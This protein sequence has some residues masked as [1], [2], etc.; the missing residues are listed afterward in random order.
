MTIKKPGWV[1]M[2]IDDIKAT[3]KGS[4]VSGPFG[5]NISAKYFTEDG[6][7][8][9]RGNNLTLG[10]KAFVDSGFVFI[11][12]EKA[13]ELRNCEAIPGDII[14]TAAGT[15]GQVGLIPSDGSYPKYIVSNKQLRLRC[16]EEIAVPE[17]LYYYFSAPSIRTYIANQNTGSSVPLLTLGILKRVPVALPPLPIQKKIASILSA[18]DD[19]IENNNRRIKILEEMAQNIY[20]EWFVHFRYPGH[21]DVPMVDSELGQIPQGW[22]VKKLEQFAKVTMGQSPK[23]EFYN[24]TGEGLPFHQGVTNFG[25]RYPQ[26]KVYCTVENRMADVGDILLSVRAPVGRMNLAPS[27]MVIGRGLC[28][29]KAKENQRWYLFRHLKQVF[30]EEDTMG[31][32]T[33]FQSVTKQEVV[34]IRL[35]V[36][37]NPSMQDFHG[38]V[39]P[40]E[41]EIG[42]FTE[43]TQN[44]RKTRDLLLPKL[45]SGQ[46]DVEELDIKV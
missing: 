46:L 23:S 39:G 30:R 34:G 33:V 43:K 40:I 8:V 2:T 42:L 1:N 28:G 21:E 3:P 41:Q 15:L 13:Y 18:Y 19:L 22:E 20:R 7:P 16:N 31:G 25:D 11:S 24:E 26:H 35:L 45:I 14:F 44:L 10:K 36:P 6:V 29:I 17:Y 38:L 12:E 5:S 9:I 37:T 27:R 32:G 4:L